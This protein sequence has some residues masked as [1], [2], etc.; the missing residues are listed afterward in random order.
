MSQNVNRL[1]GRRIVITRSPKQAKR[2]ADKLIALNAEPLVFPV[3]R[4]EPLESAALSVALQNLATY[5]WLIFTSANAVRFF[6]GHL[7][8]I[9]NK[10]PK[11]AT[12]GSATGDKLTQLGITIDYTPDQF[13]GEQLVH[14]L[15]D[16]TG[17]RVLLPRA[18]IGR[19]EIV[20]LLKQNGADVDDI[21]L[22]DTVT[23]TPSPES[24]AALRQG[25]DIITFTSPSSVRNFLKIIQEVA[26]DLSATITQAKSFPI[27]P[28]TAAEME[29][30]AI[31]VTAI[32][33]EYTIDGLIATMIATTKPN[34]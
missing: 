16:L 17:Q 23:A 30:Q 29:K 9:P 19:P 13:I 3:I 15:G 8:E 12:V 24:L 2:L 7:P 11:V 33:H 1:N 5:D 32:P 21:P 10:L 27:G 25:F 31:P 14:G 28:V 26:P 4:F 22:Y 6:W 18:K 20:A 34:R